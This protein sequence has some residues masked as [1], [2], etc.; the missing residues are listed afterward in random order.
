MKEIGWFWRRERCTISTGTTR[1]GGI[2]LR[3]CTSNRTRPPQTS[4]SRINAPLTASLFRRFIPGTLVMSLSIGMIMCVLP[5]LSSNSHS[6]FFSQLT[7]DRGQLAFL[8]SLD[9]RSRTGRSTPN[10]S[11]VRSVLNQERP[12]LPLQT[13]LEASIRALGL[14]VE[15]SSFPRTTEKCRGS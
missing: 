7:Q 3:C 5:P 10:S 15:A 1:L 13:R 14:L 11:V 2:S 8:L 12:S 4:N 6:H 9:S